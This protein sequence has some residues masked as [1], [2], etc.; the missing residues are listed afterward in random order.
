MAITKATGKKTE[1]RGTRIRRILHFLTVVVSAALYA[2]VV[3]CLFCRSLSRLC[4]S[5]SISLL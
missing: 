5:L 4:L 2:G 1:T 3:F